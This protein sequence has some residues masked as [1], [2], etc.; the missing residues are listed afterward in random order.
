[1]KLASAGC[2]SCR[3]AASEFTVSA[4]MLLS[5]PDLSPPLSNAV[6]ISRSEVLAAMSHALDLTEGQ[7]SGHTLRSCRI[8]MRIAE[9]LGLAEA[10]RSALFYALLIKDAGCS[11]NAARFATLFGAP[12]CAG[13]YRMRLGDWHRSAPMAIRTARTVGMG[14]GIRARLF[15]LREIARTPDVTR[16]L[17]QIRCD[18]GAAIALRLGFDEATGEAIRHLDEHWCGAGYPLG[19]AGEEIP[20]LARIANLAQT[21]EVFFTRSGPAAALRVAN[22]RRGTWFDPRLVKLTDAWRRDHDWWRSLRDPDLES[23]V[24][25]DEP[26]GRGR[27]IGEAELDRIAEAF[28]EIIDAKSPFTFRHS[29]NVAGYAAGIAEELGLGHTEAARLRQ[30]GYLHDVGKLGVSSL[31]LEK[32]GPLTPE[33]R[34]EVERHPAHSWEILSRVSA[35]RGFAWT[36]ALHH[37]RLDGSG[38]PWKL[39]RRDLSPGARILAVADVYEALT[40]DRPYRAGMSR[41]M[42]MDILHRDARTGLWLTAVSALESHLDS[43]AAAA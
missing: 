15:H 25:A 19:L 22:R 38:Y 29:V 18:R 6:Q 27:P 3:P 10:E 16:Q 30:A 7:P 40:A 2:T 14:R 5:K 9:E 31:I 43:A 28:A 20:L 21:L 39:T 17:I 34:R 26:G 36:A 11:S 41:K 1:M 24:V 4:V 32:S 37:E 35:F 12:D 13:K 33:E 23:R 42:A 8:G